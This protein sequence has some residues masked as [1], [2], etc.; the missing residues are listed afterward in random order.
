MFKMEQ[1][2]FSCRHIL[3]RK[4][5][6]SSRRPEI[7]N[8]GLDGRGCGP[9]WQIWRSTNSSLYRGVFVRRAPLLT[10][11]VRSVSFSFTATQT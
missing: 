9:P 10:D 6:A 3:G 5:S 4:G 11:G 2:T 8:D 1:T 7:A